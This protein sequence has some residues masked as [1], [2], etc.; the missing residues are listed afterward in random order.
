MNPGL[1]E[2]FF[3]FLKLG[4][5]SFGG[6]V[7]HIALMDRELVDKKKWM[8][9]DE[10]LN[11]I[12]MSNL[13]PGPNST[14]VALHIGYH[15]AGIQ[16]ML[17]AGLGFISPAVILVISLSFLLSSFASVNFIKE[18]INGIKPA[19]ILII[20]FA[21]ISFSK[22]VFKKYTHFFVGLIAIAMCFLGFNELIVLFSAGVFGILLDKL[23]NRDNQNKN[24]LK[25]FTLSP[26]LIFI[27]LSFLK[28]GALIYGSGYVLFAFYESEFVSTGLLTKNNLMDAIL[29]G[30]ITPGPLF[31]SSAYI[32]YLF[33]GLPGAVLAS[34]G[35]F[36]PAFIFVYLINKIYKKIS[37]N[38]TFKIFLTYLNVSSVALI[39]F[40]CYN[41]SIETFTSNLN[42][43]WKLII[44][45]III[46]LIMLKFRN[47]NSAI[48]ILISFVLSVGLYFIP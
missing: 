23:I 25:F 30:E 5:V 9:K 32:G 45:A 14:E 17:A 40:V 19:L 22:N 10:Y 26:D 36:L 2:L 3:T 47:I 44:V 35:I 16:G 28:I 37:G 42:D 43:L 7:A 34:I 46:L 13:I 21:A 18:I 38:K 12:S 41:L 15:K 20:L 11:F 48:I 6:P 33:K 1:K 31:S 4:L 24:D 29:L 39:L 27:F 8:T